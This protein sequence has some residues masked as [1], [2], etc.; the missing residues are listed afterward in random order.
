MQKFVHFIL[1]KTA[2]LNNSQANQHIIICTYTLFYTFTNFFA[3]FF[4]IRYESIPSS[5][6]LQETTIT[7]FPNG[8]NN[9]NIDLEKPIA[10]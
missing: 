5:R 3:R 6:Q 4:P 1:N 2:A 9:Y 8:N 10:E 7:I